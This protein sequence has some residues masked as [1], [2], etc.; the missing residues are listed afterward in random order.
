VMALVSSDGPENNDDGVTSADMAAAASA[1]MGLRSGVSVL[2]GVMVG[3]RV[4]QARLLPST[5][6]I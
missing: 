2:M 6:L 5:E 1:S 4:G 3:L